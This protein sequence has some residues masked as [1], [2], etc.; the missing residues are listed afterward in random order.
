MDWLDSSLE[1]R[2]GDRPLFPERFSS[3]DSGHLGRVAAQDPGIGLE[4]ALRKE[5]T[6]TLP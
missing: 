4:E 2:S 1:L 6:V 3:P 5:G